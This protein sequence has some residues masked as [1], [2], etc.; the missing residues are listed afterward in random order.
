MLHSVQ[1]HYWRNWLKYFTAEY[2]LVLELGV[3][4]VLGFGAMD[5]LIA[6]LDT[7]AF[8]FKMF[9]W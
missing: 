2:E 6:S 9:E 8:T 4:I 5:I 3:N 7:V 1:Y